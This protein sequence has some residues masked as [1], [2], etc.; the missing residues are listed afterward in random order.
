MAVLQERMALLSEPA[1]AQ[2]IVWPE[3]P[4]PFLSE[5]DSFRK[6]MGDLAR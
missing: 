6:Y 2:L 3:A 1:N 5:T 4:A